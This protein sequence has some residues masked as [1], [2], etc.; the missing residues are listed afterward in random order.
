MSTLD[1]F[2]ATKDVYMFCRQ[3]CFKL[4]YDRPN[5]LQEMSREDRGLFQ[6]L[7]DL[8]Q[9]GEDFTSRQKFLA[10][11]PAIP[12]P[13]LNLFPSLHTFFNSVVQGIQQIRPNNILG[14]NITKQEK[15]VLVRLQNNPLFVVKEADKGG[16]I[17]LW[18]TDA[19]LEEARRQISNKDF[20]VGLPSDPTMFFKKKYDKLIQSGRDMSIITKKEFEFLKVESP[21]VPTFYLLPKIHKYL[22]KPKK[23]VEICRVLSTA[24]GFE[25]PVIYQG[26]LCFY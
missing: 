11:R 4:F 2:D 16:N 24:N 1:K 20:Y 6:D 17:I 22:E 10:H 8:L 13:S 21:V 9:E 15:E 3:L 14:Q 19:Y 18:S 12:T 7:M 23:C 26:V 5:V 25:S